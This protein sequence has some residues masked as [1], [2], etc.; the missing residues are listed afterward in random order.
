MRVTSSSL[1]L[2]AACQWWARPDVQGRALVPTPEMI[3]GTAVHA[4]IETVLRDAALQVEPE[5]DDLDEDVARMVDTWLTWW[6]GGGEA[7]LRGSL[8]GEWLPE[9][10][11][12][13]DSSRDTARSLGSVRGRAYPETSA[14]E[15][16]GT[17]DAVL[18]DEARRAAVVVDWKTG[19]DRAK[20][21]A[22][23]AEN[24]QLRGYALMTS[25][26]LDLDEV[27]VAIVRIRTDGTVQVT[28]QTY[29]SLELAAVADEL[30]AQLAAV[31]TAH[32]QPGLHCRRCRAVA[33][34]PATAA[35]ADELVPRNPPPEP[36]PLVVNADN[37]G[38]LLVRLRAV[39]AACDQ[40]EAALKTFADA[41]GGVQVN[42]KTW[43]K[44]TTERSSIRLD[45][46]EA[47]VALEALHT[48]GVGDAV[49]HKTT[50]SKA[51]IERVLKAAGHKGKA[52]T[53][54]VLGVMEALSAAGAVRTTT[55][56]SYREV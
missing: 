26:A 52:L 50:T 53:A 32:P 45:G 27:T 49:E 35:A 12:A 11:Y 13:Y 9:V 18:I 29:D 44:V 34:C 10:A 16:A 42:D 33:E 40:V 8:A 24:R 3:A 4:A 28:R 51:A 43:K 54:Q 20:L 22:D 38:A 23:A 7:D 14:T 36:V 37:A 2:L 25:R 6:D 56:E 55:V 1:P 48:A 17:I 46:P 31:P 47:A 15:I 19:D 39:Q 41:N 5:L 21:T 30:R